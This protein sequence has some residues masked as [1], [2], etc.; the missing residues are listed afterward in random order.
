VE[1]AGNI[2]FSDAKDWIKE[3]KF[4]TPGKLAKQSVRANSAPKQGAS[5]KKI[6]KP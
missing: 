4:M 5:T 3:P 2:N 1:S 6:A